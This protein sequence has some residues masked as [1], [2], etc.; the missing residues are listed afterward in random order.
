M[1]K[2]EYDVA[3]KEHC[4]TSKVYCGKDGRRRIV[5]VERDGGDWVVTRRLMKSRAVAAE[6]FRSPNRLYLRCLPEDELPTIIEEAEDE[7]ALWRTVLDRYLQQNPTIHQPV[8]GGLLPI[9]FEAIANML[10]LLSLQKRYPYLSKVDKVSRKVPAAYL[11]G[12]DRNEWARL[13]ASRMDQ[14]E[15]IA[16]DLAMDNAHNLGRAGRFYDK[17]LMCVNAPAPKEEEPLLLW[18]E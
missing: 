15:A 4:Y 3:V 8:E 17:L 6:I 16:R 11:M 10:E 5:F 14:L 9:T 2:P 1:P 7:V 13:L 18:E 12:T